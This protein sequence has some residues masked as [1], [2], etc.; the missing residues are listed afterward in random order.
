VKLRKV[1]KLVSARLSVLFTKKYALA[2]ALVLVAREQSIAGNISGQLNLLEP[3]FGELV[4]HQ[5]SRAVPALGDSY[6]K[7]E[8]LS[9]ISE[10]EL[11]IQTEIEK[12]HVFESEN[13]YMVEHNL[14]KFLNVSQD[15][16]RDIIGV[17][18]SGKRYLYGNYY[19]PL[20]LKEKR[21][22]NEKQLKGPIRTCDGGPLYFGAEYEIEAKKIVHHAFNGII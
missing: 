9:E 6:F 5:C 8:S 10:F 12:T 21:F 4:M 1:G 17:V 14:P 19:P 15:W 2:L 7:P 3:N 18:R 16:S 11:A 20:T 13:R 22:Y